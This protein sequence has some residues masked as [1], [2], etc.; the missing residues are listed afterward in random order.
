MRQNKTAPWLFRAGVVALAFVT[1]SCA[2]H[3]IR[4]LETSDRVGYE[5]T[6][7]LAKEYEALAKKESRVYNDQIDA[8]HFAVKGIQAAGGLEVLPE[9]PQH[10]DLPESSVAAV[11]EGRERL[12]FAVLKGG[13]GRYIA[14]ELSAKTVVLYDCW[15]EELEEN[16]QPEHIGTCQKGFMDSLVQLEAT[17]QKE[18]PTFSV[19]FDYNSSALTDDGAKMVAE[20]AKVAKFMD[21]HT[22][23]VIGHTDPVGGRKHNLVLSQNRAAAVADAL[24]KHGITNPRIIAVGSGELDTGRE[25]EPRNRRVDIH[26]H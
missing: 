18:A 15:V 22:V 9:N 1:A 19:W 26:L 17:I 21:H 12:I 14:P 3:Q 13:R 4:K 10:W 11:T 5:Y 2:E 8:Q 24:K 7:A 20:A 16:H 25:V 6:N 23:N